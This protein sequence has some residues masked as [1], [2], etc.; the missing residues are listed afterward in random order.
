MREKNS[1]L[2]AKKYFSCR[3]RQSGNSCRRG[4]GRGDGEQ[5]PRKRKGTACTA[6]KNSARILLL[7]TTT[8]RNLKKLFSK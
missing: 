3:R 6:Q 8:T 7:R 4:N 2:T 5:T 1:A